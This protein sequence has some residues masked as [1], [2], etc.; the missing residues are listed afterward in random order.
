[1]NR[2]ECL[3]QIEKELNDL[4]CKMIDFKTRDGVI[5]INFQDNVLNNYKFYIAYRYMT[6]KTLH[7]RIIKGVI[8]Q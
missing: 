2:F 3:R 1:M 7:D 5:E 8:E 6:P 4:G